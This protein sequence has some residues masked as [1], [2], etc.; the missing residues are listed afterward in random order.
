MPKHVAL[1]FSPGLIVAG[2][3]QNLFL[4]FECRGFE[5][6]GFERICFELSGS[7]RIGFNRIHFGS[8]SHGL[9]LPRIFR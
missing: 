3:L 8:M 1:M 4:G 2:Y 7:E 6:T 5:V 9:A